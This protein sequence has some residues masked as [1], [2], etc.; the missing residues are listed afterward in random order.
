MEIVHSE[1]VSPC[2]PRVLQAWSH[3]VEQD[4]RGEHREAFRV[5]LSHASQEVQV[6]RDPEDLDPMRVSP[7]RT[8]SRFK[9]LFE[10]FPRTLIVVGDAERL[11]REVQSLQEAM[12]RDGVDVQAEWV[13]DAVHDI[14][15]MAEGWWDRKVV[16]KTWGVIG[17]WAVG[18]QV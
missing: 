16:E 2:S 5:S 12:E 9:K 4:V 3:A 7:Y 13:K 15:I 10:G 17:E 14:L 11:V 6:T 18:F 8:T 1:Y